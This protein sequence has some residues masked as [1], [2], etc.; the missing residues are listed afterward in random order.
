METSSIRFLGCTYNEIAGEA[1]SMHKCQGMSQLLP[2]PAPT[3]GGG[4]FVAVPA[5]YANYR[6]RDTV[7]DGGVAAR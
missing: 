2:L 4:G 6:L 5:V 3:S 7:L 1:R